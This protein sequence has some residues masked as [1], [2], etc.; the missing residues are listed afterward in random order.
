MRDL[1]RKLAIRGLSSLGRCEPHVWASVEAVR[2]ALEGDLSFDELADRDD[3]LAFAA[4]RG[5]L[6]RNTDAVFGPRPVGR[7]TRIM[8]TMPT[9]AADDPALARKFVGRGMEVARI[10]GAHD[11]PDTWRRIAANVRAAGDET[12]RSCPIMMDLVGPKLRTGPLVPGPQVM[13][14]KSPHA[15]PVG[16]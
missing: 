11:G 8:V 4:G 15:T 12:G 2:R 5:G 1:Q 9:E 14:C 7:V 10:N 3:P 16:S 13:R 6:D